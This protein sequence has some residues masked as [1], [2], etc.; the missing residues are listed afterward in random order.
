MNRLKFKSV[1]LINNYIQK[2]D[3]TCQKAFQERPEKN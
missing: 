1:E 3:F 2:G